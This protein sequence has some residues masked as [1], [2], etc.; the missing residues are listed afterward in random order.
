M[1][2]VARQ[3]LQRRHCDI[4][5]TVCNLQ[6]AYVFNGHFVEFF[7]LYLQ[8]EEGRRR[9]LGAEGQV[10]QNES[11]AV[12]DSKVFFRAAESAMSRLF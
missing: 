7:I 9:A 5:D 12:N 3:L 2:S 1:G 4:C 6:A 10:Q 8:F 11:G